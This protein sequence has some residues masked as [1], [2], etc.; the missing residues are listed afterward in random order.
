MPQIPLMCLK[1]DAYHSH[2]MFCFCTPFGITPWNFLL[3]YSPFTLHVLWN[4][5][6]VSPAHVL[7]HSAYTYPFLSHILN[8]CFVLPGVFCRALLPDVS[9]SILLL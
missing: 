4:A 7:V 8:F 5:V 9:Y 1:F 6:Y 3:L 2:T